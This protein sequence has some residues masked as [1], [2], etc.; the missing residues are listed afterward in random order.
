MLLGP[1][2]LLLLAVARSGNTTMYMASGNNNKMYL[3]EVGENKLTTE[4]N[5]ETVGGD[6][7]SDYNDYRTSGLY[8]ELIPRGGIL[9][10]NFRLT[11]HKILFGCCIS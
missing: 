5:N 9:A 2:L 3:L 10:S 8:F 6:D 1:L 4:S 7:Y 11:R